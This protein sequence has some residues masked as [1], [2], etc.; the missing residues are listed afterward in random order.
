MSIVNFSDIDK[1]LEK[2]EREKLKIEAAWKAVNEIARAK[3]VKL[4]RFRQQKKFFKD[5]EQ[6]MFDKDLNDVEELKRLKSLK[7]LD[8]TEIAF[9]ASSFLDE[10]FI[11]DAFARFL[12]DS[13]DEIFV[14]FDDSSN[15]WLILMCCSM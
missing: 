1:A 4:K 5:R 6:K 8:H 7:S 12:F 13:F 11:S 9:A 14:V 15:V 3:L 2:L 10:F